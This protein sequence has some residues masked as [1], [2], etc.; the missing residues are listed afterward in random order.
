MISKLESLPGG[1]LS[2]YCQMHIANSKQTSAQGRSGASLRKP[3][4]GHL[5]IYLAPQLVLKDKACAQKQSMHLMVCQMRF[6]RIPCI[7]NSTQFDE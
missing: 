3:E 1:M 5:S 7:L 2:E 6:F 4:D